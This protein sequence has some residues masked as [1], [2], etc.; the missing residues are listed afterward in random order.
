MQSTYSLGA[1][2]PNNPLDYSEPS[3]FRYRIESDDLPESAEKFCTSRLFTDSYMETEKEAQS[4]AQVIADAIGEPVSYQRWTLDGWGMPR[5]IF[6]KV[7]VKP[8]A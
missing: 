7:E 1:D 4:T 3:E 6:D 5:E 8:S 2:H